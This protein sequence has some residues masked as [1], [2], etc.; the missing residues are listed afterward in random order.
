MN[1]R[2]ATGMFRDSLIREMFCPPT[3]VKKMELLGVNEISLVSGGVSA[4]TIGKLI[5]EFGDI[6]TGFAEGC[7][8]A[9]NEWAQ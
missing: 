4:K 5:L 1:I 9:I 6:A 8:D 2:L 7:G 3:G